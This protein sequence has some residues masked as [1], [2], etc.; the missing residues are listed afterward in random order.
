MAGRES[1]NWHRLVDDFIIIGK[2]LEKL[3]FIY[4]EGKVYLTEIGVGLNEIDANRT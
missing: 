3:G 1:L 4:I 2:R